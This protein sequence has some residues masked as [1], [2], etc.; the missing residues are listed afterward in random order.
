MDEENQRDDTDLPRAGSERP[1]FAG[2]GLVYNATLG[3][4]RG[5]SAFVKAAMVG[6]DATLVPPGTGLGRGQICE[7][8]TGKF[9]PL[10]A[11][12]RVRLWGQ[13]GICQPSLIAGGVG[14]HGALMAALTGL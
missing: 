2:K 14:T 3:R 11:G 5:G 9:Q 10:L 13:R 4:Q 12:F 8:L 7:G 6:A 1:V